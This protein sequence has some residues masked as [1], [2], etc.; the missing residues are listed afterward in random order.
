MTQKLNSFERFWKELKRRKVI[1]VITVYAAIA[2][3]ILQLVDIIGPSLKWP[4]WTMTFIIV[5]LCIGFIIAVFVSWVYDI[6]P[7]GVK[8]TKPVSAVKHIDQTIL[9]TSSGWK[10]ATYVSGVII[11]ALVAFNF[12]SRRNLNADISKL[13]KSIAVLPFL[14]E[15]P[16]DS[17]KYFING[18]ME[19]V[20][21]N[22]Q[23]IKDF[24]VLSRTSTDQYKGQNR[25]TIP[26]IAKKLNVNYVVEGSG[27]K[28]GNTFRLRVQLIKAKGKEN[29]LWAKSY[30]EELRETTG[31]FSIQSQIAQAIATELKAIMTP[32]EKQ[33]IE[34]VPTSKMTAYDLYLKANDYQKE[35]QK[36]RNLSSY[37]TAVNLYDAAL[38]IDSTYAK[39]YTGLAGIYYDRYQSQMG[40]YFK[41]NYLDSM[42]VLTKIAL[43]FDDKLDD[44][45]YLQGM[46]YM[47]KGDFKEALDNFDR[48]LEI[49]PNYYSA[50]YSKGYIL[51]YGSSD[52]VKVIDNYHKALDLIRGNERPSVLRNLAYAYMDIGFFEKVKYYLNEAFTL[53]NNKAANIRY[54]SYLAF[55]QGNFEEGLNFERNLQEIDTTYA[56]STL[57]CLGDKEEAYSAARKMVE[58]YKKS[59]EL[60]LQ[61][62]HR[63]GFAFWQVGKRE[64][65]KNYLNQQ[66]RYCEESIRLDRR[67]AK[68]FAAQYDLAATYA[69]LGER[70]KA[71]IYLDEIN[72]GITL[73][74]WMKLYMMYDPLFDSIRS[75]ERFQKILQNYEAK[76]QA[77][78]D[79]VKKWLEEQGM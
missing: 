39:V 5:L 1:H 70:K 29:H 67:L 27:Q 49:N 4:D 37:Q 77:E 78:H 53:D 43:S 45:F 26:E 36:T 61:E 24:R 9:P 47:E 22:L 50:Y 13:D 48:A 25:P 19:E 20:L 64:E 2:F 11:V 33:I 52:F 56:S 76:Y 69:F 41:E 6:T 16:V 59:D 57:M 46:Y 65:A 32:E 28:Y 63:V 75:E 8:K 51:A 42:L 38:A 30:E 7:S 73:S 71:Y 62:S 12:I 40:T 21:T 31:L 68:F 44:A 58:Y 34:K 15:S 55:Y 60:N 35:Y 18:I 14:N 23:K 79:R 54:L 74:L 66:I 17:N 10:I 72:E 3:G